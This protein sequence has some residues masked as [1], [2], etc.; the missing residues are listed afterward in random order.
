MVRRVKVSRAA[1][2]SQTPT[3]IPSALATPLSS[4]Y[5]STYASE[6]EWDSE[7][8]KLPMSA[9]TLEEKKARRNAKPFPFMSLP[10]ELR[11]R[12]YDYYFEGTGDV[13]DL[14]PDNYKKLH[15]KLGIQRTCRTI[16]TEVSHYFYSSRV[17]RIFP[18]HPGRFFKTKKPLLARLKPNQRSHLTSLE[19]RLGPG[20]SKPPRGWVVNPALGLHECVNVRRLVVLVECDPSDGIFN[21][22]R[23]SDGFY[24]GFCR[25]LLTEVLSEMPWLDTVTFDAWPSVKKSGAMMRTLLDVAAANNRKIRW[26]PERGWTDEPE[27]EVPVS[28]NL[29]LVPPPS[30]FNTPSVGVLVMA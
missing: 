26:G 7:I 28:R 17:F 30:E 11:L 12:V 24:E 5:P 27:D 16:Y 9:L 29:V 19:L 21:G 13:L 15:K 20:W 23:R 6:A 10:S 18:T 3:P 1:G 4:A 22:F 8:N 2:P 25:S 14:D